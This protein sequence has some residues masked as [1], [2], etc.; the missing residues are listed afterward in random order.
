MAHDQSGQ[1]SIL[2][3]FGGTVTIDDVLLHYRQHGRSAIGFRPVDLNDKRMEIARDKI[4][5]RCAVADSKIKSEELMVR[6]RNLRARASAW[7]PREKI[8]RPSYL[9]SEGNPGKRC[10]PD[11]QYYREYRECQ[12]IRLS[13]YSYPW[14]ERKG[15][16]RCCRCCGEV[17]MGNRGRAFAALQSTCFMAYWVSDGTDPMDPEGLQDP[18][19]I[20]RSS[21]L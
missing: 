14:A 3:I 18:R 15:S 12:L 9:V 1:L 21:R 11:Q 7:P 10:C 2:P 4:Y 17:F 13:A 8:C 19:V 16:V 6:W 5:R 20:L